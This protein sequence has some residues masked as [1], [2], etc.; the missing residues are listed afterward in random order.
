M[1]AFWLMTAMWVAGAPVDPPPEYALAPQ[2]QMVRVI[3]SGGVRLVPDYSGRA[4]PQASPYHA[5]PVLQALSPAPAPLSTVGAPGAVAPAAGA[6]Q[7]YST[8]VPAPAVTAPANMGVYSR[9]A[10]SVSQSGYAPSVYAKPVSSPPVS[11]QDKVG[12]EHDYSRI[13]GYLYYVHADGG[14]WVLRYAALDQ[15]DRYG[16]SVV[17]A[18]GLEMG[19]YREGDLV[20]VYGEV[21]NEGRAMRSLGGALYRVQ[22]IEMVERR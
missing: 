8:L 5:T 9:T 12:H 11:A 7:N 1:D 19:N 16:G 20:T 13:T 10:V 21:L 22:M 4:G 14:C 6:M 15:V 3:S 17:L 2:P 18:A